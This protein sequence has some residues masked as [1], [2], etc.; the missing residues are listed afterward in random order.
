MANFDNDVVA[1]QWDNV[2]RRTGADSATGKPWSVSGPA[3]T[4]NVAKHFEEIPAN[5]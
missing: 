4:Y 3:V 5:A 1:I 2:V